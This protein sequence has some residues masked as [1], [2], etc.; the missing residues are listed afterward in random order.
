MTT[1][2]EKVD[3]ENEIW[4]KIAKLEREHC[5]NKQKL[6]DEMVGIWE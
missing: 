3:M 6:F 2:N 1:Y 5:K 4:L